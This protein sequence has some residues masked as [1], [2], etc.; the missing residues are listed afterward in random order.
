ML[1][2]SKSINITGAF[3]ILA[4]CLIMGANVVAIKISLMGVGVFTAA[5]IRFTM[6]ALIILLWAVITGQKLVVNRKQAF[7]LLIIS[8]IFIVQLSLFY[9]GLSKT[10]ASRGSL[11]A[12]IQPFF[13]LILAHF[14]INGDRINRRKIIGMML[15]FCGVAFVLLQKGDINSD[16]RIGD[17]IILMAAFVWACNGVYTKRVLAGLKPFQVVLYPTLVAG[18]LFL[19]EAAVWDARMV[20]NINLDTILALLYQGVIVTSFGFVAWNAMLQRY[21]AVALHSFVF[22]MPMVGVILGGVILQEPIT[23]NI[24]IAMILVATG[25]L[26]VNSRSRRETQDFG[27]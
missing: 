18:P 24:G 26:V 16:L 9:L 5:G 11:L 21:G 15:A 4:L 7:Q 22:V 8:V 17:G 14:F 27:F 19:L 13:V 1:I 20:S 10:Y 3:S 12:N 23:P 2:D 6:A 25:I